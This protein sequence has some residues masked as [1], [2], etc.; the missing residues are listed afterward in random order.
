[1]AVVVFAD[2][3]SILRISSNSV[4]AAF[5]VLAHSRFKRLVVRG[6]GRLRPLAEREGG[7][8]GMN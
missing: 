1:M 8:F 7:P 2:L 6:S 5:H 3:I 4:A